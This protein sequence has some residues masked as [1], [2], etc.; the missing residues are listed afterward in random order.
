VRWRDRFDRYQQNHRWLGF[1]VAVGKKF[2][3]DRAGDLAA[4][5][6]YYSFFSLFPLLLAAVTVLGFVL[7]GN[8]GLQRD[9]LDSALADFPVVG[10]QLRENAGHLNASG[11]ALAVGLGGLL[12]AG[13]GAVLA[14]ETAMNGVWNVPARERAGFVGQRLRALA[15]LAVLGL[16]IVAATALAAVVTVF[17]PAGAVLGGVAAIAVDVGLFLVAFRLLPSIDPPWRELW[18]GALVAGVSWAIL[19]LAGSVIVDR[20]LSGA[21]DVYGAF[22]IVIGLL[23]WIYLQAQVMLVAAEINVVRSRHLWPVPLRQPAAVP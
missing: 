12:W 20:Q 2:G 5:I 3:A 15:V 10:A 6:A 17:G 18:P 21:S 14:A 23:S 22:A 11:V 7:D 8:P 1:P 16:G 4:L 9:V 13:L 19:Q